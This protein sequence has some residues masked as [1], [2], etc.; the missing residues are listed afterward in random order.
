MPITIR[1]VAKQ[2]G[3]SIS[4]ASRALNGRM[5]VSDEV[6]ARVLAAANDLHYTVNQHARVLKGAASKTL[7]IILYNTSSL[8]YN[9]TLTRGIYD[10]ATPRGY[11]LMV[12]SSQ[13]EAELEL[14]AHQMLRQNHVD[15][16]LINSVE[17]G[18]EPLR[19]LEVRNTPFVLLNRRVK[20]MECD[21]VMVDYQRGS[22]LATTHLLELGHRR[23]LYQLG[24]HDHAPTLERLSGY[25]Q[26]LQDFGVAFDPSLV[27]YAAKTIEAYEPVLEAM[28]QLQP[29]PTAIMAYNDEAAILVLKALSDLGL[30]V[31]EDISVVGQNDLSFAPYLIP[32]LTTIAQS[33]REMGTSAM[34]ILLQK[35]AWSDGQPWIPQQVVLEPKPTIRLST[36]PPRSPYIGESQSVLNS[37]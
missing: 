6:R 31:P 36:A 13:G 8:T 20:E 19:Q 25:R 33:V 15:G 35:L 23:I 26:A 2:A 32:P 37:M 21:Y 17:N 12:Y 27:V 28:K 7:G 29:R 24:A 14:Q 5:D 3:V 4:T 10:I 30:R 18:V 11:S 34:E 16:V 1:D 9:A 22:Y